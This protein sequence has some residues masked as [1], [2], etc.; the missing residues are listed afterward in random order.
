MGVLAALT[1]GRSAPRTVRLRAACTVAALSLAWVAVGRVWAGSWWPQPTAHPGL[2]QHIVLETSW[3]RLLPLGPS[4]MSVTGYLFWRAWHGPGA[5]TDP[6]PAIGTIVCFRIVS[7]GLN[8]TALRGTVASVHEVMRA[9]PLF[10]YRVEVVT[11]QA[12]DLPPHSL[13][14]CFVVPKDYRTPNGSMYKA[15]ALTYVQEQSGL[16]DTAWVLHLDEESHAT[17]S[18]VRGIRIAV[19]EEDRSGAHRIGQGAILYHRNLER[20]CFLTLADMMRTGD[21]FGRFYLQYRVGQT[22]FGMHGSFVLVRVSVERE[23]NFDVGPQGSITED[24]FWALCQR[25]LGRGVRWVDG[26]VA[27]QGTLTLSD[28]FKQR[29]RWFVGLTVVVRSA[30]VRL[31]HRGLLGVTV[32]LW[33]ISWVG[34][35]YTFLQIVSGTTIQP[36]ISLLGIIAFASYLSLYYVGL[37]ANLR[38]RGAN[39][40][41]RLWYYSVLTTFV[42]AFCVLEAAAIVFALIKPDRGF[43]VIDKEPERLEIG[44]GWEDSDEAGSCPGDGDQD[45]DHDGAPREL[46][47][48]L[49]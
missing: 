33:S 9:D 10:P 6:M 43:Y 18:L 21:D 5:A 2:L 14:R 7:R 41:V 12:V 15:R 25:E 48:S 1:L 32:W 37:A 19:E 17:P 8:V 45:S 39:F 4:L 30:P 28:F 20:R 40:R 16:S 31:H 34:V 22:V 3:L 42:L 49:A 26:Y 29:R 13:L 38:D 44:D 36:L 46:L 11:D 27:E 35:L 24:A 23:L 47:S